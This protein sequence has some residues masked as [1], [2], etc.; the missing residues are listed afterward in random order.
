[1]NHAATRRGRVRLD[2]DAYK[3]LMIGT[4]SLDRTTQI[5]VAEGLSV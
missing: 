4:L 5:Q 3:A 1:M 2:L